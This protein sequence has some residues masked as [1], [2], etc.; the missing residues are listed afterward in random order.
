MLQ[1]TA[2]EERVFK[3]LAASP[4]GAALRGVLQRDQAEAHLLLEAAND[5]RVLRQLQGRAQLLRE[6]LA[7]L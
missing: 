2:N 7:A 3:A 6:L 1:L 5:D 4:D